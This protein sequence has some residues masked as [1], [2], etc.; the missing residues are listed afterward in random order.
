M[1]GEGDE[2]VTAAEYT[3]EHAAYVS[4]FVPVMFS[5][6]TYT[7]EQYA[8]LQVDWTSL[9]KV[10]NPEENVQYQLYLATKIEKGNYTDESYNALQSVIAEIEKTL[11]NVW[12]SQQIEVPTGYNP[13][14]VLTLKQF[15]EMCIRDSNRISYI[16]ASC[17]T[18][19]IFRFDRFAGLYKAC[20]HR[21]CGYFIG[22][23]RCTLYKKPI[24]S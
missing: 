6:A 13:V 4:V 8:R 15:N 3:W 11:S 2:P 21:F 18:R 16:A 7:G 14:P 20:K 10:E 24:K 19:H 9:E 1:I 12:P 17:V 23:Y 22:G 5:I